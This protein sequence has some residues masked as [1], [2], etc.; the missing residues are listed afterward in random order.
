MSIYTRLAQRI[1]VADLQEPLGPS[2]SADMNGDEVNKVCEEAHA[3]YGYEPFDRISLVVDKA[4]TPTH[5]CEPP[6]FDAVEDADLIPI[7][8]R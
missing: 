3:K 6:L 1:T 2:L 5:Y 4:G 7:W 8:G